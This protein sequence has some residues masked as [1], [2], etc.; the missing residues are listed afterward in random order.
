MDRASF[1]AGSQAGAH[2]GNQT[3]AQMAGAREKAVYDRLRH[4]VIGLQI[5]ARSDVFGLFKFVSATLLRGCRDSRS[6]DGLEFHWFWYFESTPLPICCLRAMVAGRTPAFRCSCGT[7]LIFLSCV[8]SWRKACF[9][10]IHGERGHAER[11]AGTVTEPEPET[12]LSNAQ[13]LWVALAN[14]CRGRSRL[15]AAAAMGRRRST[16]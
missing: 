1:S 16:R 12:N 6:G 5:A 10:L 14:E 7:R 13:D 15:S 9:A 2:R 11:S 3:I 8:V 4:T